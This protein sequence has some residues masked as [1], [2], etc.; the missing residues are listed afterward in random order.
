MKSYV[1]ML[2]LLA[3]ITQLVALELPEGI[4]ES[5]PR[6]APATKLADMDGNHQD[7]D[8]YHG[9]WVFVHFWASWCS[10]CRK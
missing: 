9:Q 7:I 8:Q 5:Q 4:I 10:P 1:L 3:P 6:S 2:S